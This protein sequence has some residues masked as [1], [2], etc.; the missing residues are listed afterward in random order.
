MFDPHAPWPFNFLSSVI[1]LLVIAGF[2]FIAGSLVWNAI[3]N[4]GQPEQSAPARVV[5]KRLQ[6]WGGAGEHGASTSYFVTFEFA[7]GERKELKVPAST[8][9]LIVEGDRGGLTYRGTWFRR[10][11]RET[12][13]RGESTDA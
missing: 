2:V 13:G 8:Y 9:G 3:S 4:L 10:F 12:V 5:S 11:E 1:P 7:G 6:V